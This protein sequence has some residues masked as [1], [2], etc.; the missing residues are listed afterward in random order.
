MSRGVVG[1]LVD[2]VE[3]EGDDNDDGDDD[4]EEDAK[5]EVGDNGRRE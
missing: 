3:T 4:D 5:D 2:R 1:I